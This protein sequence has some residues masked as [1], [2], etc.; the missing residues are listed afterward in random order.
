[1]FAYLFTFLIAM[2]PLIELRGAIPYAQVQGLSIWQALPVAILGNLVPI[3]IIYFLAHRCL[4]WGSQ[5]PGRAGRFFRYFLAKGERAGEKLQAKAGRFGLF[6]ALLLFVGI[7]LPGTG[8]WTGTLA[9]S[10]L[11]IDPKTSLLAASCGV[12]LAGALVA[13]VSSG[14]LELINRF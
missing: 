4:V 7:P 12:L 14:V 8:A 3:P 10:F 5:R 9:A 1:M 2:S 13:L 11:E 6:L